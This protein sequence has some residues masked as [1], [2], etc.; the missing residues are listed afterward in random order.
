M[1]EKDTCPK[2]KRRISEK[3]QFWGFLPCPVRTDA[4]FHKKRDSKRK[5]FWFA[6]SSIPV[7]QLLS[8]GKG[9]PYWHL[10]LQ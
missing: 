1:R 4:Q 6:H 9:R 5:S 8:G 10:Q 2:L 3:L 7:W